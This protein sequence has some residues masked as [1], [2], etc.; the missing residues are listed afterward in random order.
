MIFGTD[1]EYLAVN[2]LGRPVPAHK[3]GFGDKAH[4]TVL[5]NPGYGVNDGWESRAFRDGY[6]IE[7]NIQPNT[8]R[9]TVTHRM[10]RAL[11]NLARKI[12]PKYKLVATA[13]VKISLKTDLKNAPEDVLQFGCDPSYCAYEGEAKIPLIDAISHPFRYGGGHI[14]YGY[15]AGDRRLSWMKNPSNHPKF[16]KLLDRHVGVPL[17][18]LFDSKQSFMRRRFYGQ[19]GEFRSQR[20]GKLPHEVGVEYRTPGPEV[21]NAPWIASY[22]MGAGRYIGQ[23]F[24][25]LAKKWDKSMEDDLRLAINTGEGA[26]KMLK[27]ALLP[28]FHECPKDFRPLKRMV[29]TGIALLKSQADTVN[30]GFYHWALNNRLITLDRGY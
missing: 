22:V 5:Y 23:N 1:P 20:Y 7:V 18:Y 21:W 9:Q 12:A 15:F 29:P 26:E 3:V 4:K 30:D 25:E 28:K 14:H 11:E 27:H 2:K 16:I 17:A 19:A 24:K 6:M 10:K 8:C 13:A